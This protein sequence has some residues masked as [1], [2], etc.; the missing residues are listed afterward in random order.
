MSANG[1]VIVGAGQAGLQMAVDL[2]KHGYSDP[3][4]MLGAEGHPPYQ[5]PPLSKKYLLGESACEALWLRKPNFLQDSEI[6]LVTGVNVSAASLEADGTGSVGTDDGR[7]WRFG[8][9]ALATGAAPRRLPVPGGDAPNVLVMRTLADAD[10]LR[11]QFDDIDSLVV[12]GGGFIGLE[13]AAV[14]RARGNQVTVVEA[15]ERLLARVAGEHLGQFYLEAHR[16]RGVDVR[17]GAGVTAIETD[18]SGR[19]TGVVLDSGEVIAADAVVVG[20]GVVRDRGLA[21][22]LGIDWAG[23]YVVDEFARTSAPTVLAAGDCAVYRHPMSPADGP[24]CIESVQNA[25][26]QAKVAAATIAGV[27]GPPYGSVPWFWSDQADIKL[28][29]AGL[30]DGADET[31]LRGEP[32]SESFSVLHLRE[33]RLIAIEAVNRSPDFMAVRKALTQGTTLTDRARAGD[34]DTKLAD[35][36]S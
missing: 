6:E 30:T 10:T 19:A 11:A 1:T 33:G 9:L 4:T 36:I 16:R 34:I 23:G 28:Q 29:I 5:R 7:S 14:M 8:H 32:G 3:I 26:D 31:I 17:L 21:D 12:V 18:P 13:T 24:A 27:D 2:R 15:R 35:L 20:I 22:Q 25:V